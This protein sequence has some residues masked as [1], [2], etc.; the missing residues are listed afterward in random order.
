MK[1]SEVVKTFIPITAIDQSKILQELGVRNLVNV[2]TGNR[3]HSTRNIKLYDIKASKSNWDTV[4]YAYNSVKDPRYF[5]EGR[6]LETSEIYLNP[7]YLFLLDISRKMIEVDANLYNYFISNMK[8]LKCVERS[9]SSKVISEYICY[10]FDI[11]K[12][13]A[14]FSFPIVAKKIYGEDSY[15]Y[16]LSPNYETYLKEGYFNG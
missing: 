5:N 11:C 8:N 4:I 12:K 3:F 14:S 6:I 1:K 10:N 9:K 2:R 13:I 15:R 7:K 16:F